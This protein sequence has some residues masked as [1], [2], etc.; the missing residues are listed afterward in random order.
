MKSAV[1]FANGKY[2]L[3][4]VRFALEMKWKIHYTGSVKECILFIERENKALLINKD[5]LYLHYKIGATSLTPC[6]NNTQ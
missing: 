1:I 5:Q 3:M 4:G 2:V 6:Q